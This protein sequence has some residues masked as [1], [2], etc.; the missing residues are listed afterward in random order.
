MTETLIT[1]TSIEGLTPL[2]TT[3]QRSFD[4][5]YGTVKTVLTDQ[6]AN[7]FS[8]PVATQY[9]DKLDWYIAIEGNPRKLDDLGKEERADV[10]LLL[11]RLIADI[12]AK[13]NELLTKDNPDDQRLGEALS[14]AIYFP[15]TNSIYV[16]GEKN[17]FQPIIVNWAWVADSQRAVSGTLSDVKK[18]PL[19]VQQTNVT[20]PATLVDHNNTTD[21][22]QRDKKNSFSLWWLLW[23]GWFI[24]FLIIS[25]ILFLLFEA[26]AIT[27]KL[28]PNYCPVSHSEITELNR[29]SQI[30]RGQ[31][32]SVEREIGIMRRACY[33]Q[34]LEPEG[35]SNLMEL[36]RVPEANKSEPIELPR[37][38]KASIP[39]TDEFDARREATN[40]QIGD[41]TFSLIWD[42]IDDLDLH[43]ICPTGSE[44]WF[45]ETATCNG[46]LDVDSNARGTPT[47]NPIENIYFTD[48]VNGIYRVNIRYYYSRT[49]GQ[50]RSFQ[51]QITDRGATQTLDGSVSPQQPDWTIDYVVE[52]N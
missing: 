7:L 26:C 32:A 13:A 9:G 17:A 31:I 2:G 28:F 37:I 44:I 12:S 22:I 35:L 50:P 3:P 8:E 39:E 6:H 36:P 42:S 33:T 11:N 14:N 5:I 16:I 34:S 49:R 41:L 47:R 43:V 51:L 29:Q 24:L 4:L 38:P 25:G 19:V 52:A 10:T 30:L 23:I 27:P 48:P 21:L 20:T 46:N 18:K 1:T 40:A 45:R 15:G